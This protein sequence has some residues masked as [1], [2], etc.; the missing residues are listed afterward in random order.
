MCWVRGHIEETMYMVAHNGSSD[1][2]ADSKGGGKAVFRP[3]II[4]HGS[5]VADLTFGPEI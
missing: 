4:F 2:H 3:F 1:R 5:A